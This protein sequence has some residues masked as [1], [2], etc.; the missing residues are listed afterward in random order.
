MIKK[1]METTVYNGVILEKRMETSL[2]GL[3]RVQGLG[4]RVQGLGF[5]V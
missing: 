5:R 1:K 4:I 3:H 2:M